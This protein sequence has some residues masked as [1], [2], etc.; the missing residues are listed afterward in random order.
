MNIT[1]YTNSSM[2]NVVDKKLTNAQNVSDISFLESFGDY[3]PKVRLGVSPGSHNYA[4]INGKFYFIEDV[5]HESDS[6][7][8]I[9]LRLDV[10]MTYKK[11]IR[12]LVGWVNRGGDRAPYL[13][14]NKEPI[15]NYNSMETIEFP[16]GFDETEEGGCYVIL[17]SQSGYSD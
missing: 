9:Y 11:E 6:I 13:V 8:Y 14:D 10:L 1:L 17:T 4:E 15:A 7:H 12:N 5:R 2:S 3:S 16:A